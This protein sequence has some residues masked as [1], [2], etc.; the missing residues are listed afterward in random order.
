MVVANQTAAF[1][2][3]LAIIATPPMRTATQT[4]DGNVNGLTS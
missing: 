3:L 2:K 4:N 1:H